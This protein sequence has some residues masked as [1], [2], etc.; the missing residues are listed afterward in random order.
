MRAVLLLPLFA[1]V[2]SPATGQVAPEI[3]PD[4]GDGGT[5]A[6]Y[7]AATL[8]EAPGRM[9]RQEDP[10]E[11][12]AVP[13]AA[14]VRRILYSSTDGRFGRGIQA[15]SG[16]LYL[17]HGAP[18][19]GGWPLLVWG[20]GTFGIA[21]VCAPS[22]KR[23]TPRD[24]AYVDRWLAKGFAVVAPDYQGLGTH[25]VHPYL[26]RK[27]EGYSVLD[28]AR[29]ALSAYP[30]KIANRVVLGGQSQGSG[31]V[32]NATYVARDYAPDLK[33]LATVATGL[34]WAA[35]RRPGVQD[36][37]TI[38]PDGARVTVLRL[39]SGGT[40]PGSPPPDT[41]LSERGKALREVARTACSRDMVPVVKAQGITADNAFTRSAAEIDALLLPLDVPKTALPVPIFV[42]TGMA[43]SMIPPKRQFAATR[44]LC[45]AGTRVTFRP[46]AGITHNG[47]SVN[48]L[49]AA[50][51]WA[52][53]LLNGDRAANDCSR[54]RD[55]G[56]LQ[57]PATA[58][59]FN[60]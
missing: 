47:S 26:D 16:L 40:K 30:G 50:V 18:P 17:P 55:P 45:H 28:A 54:L 31:A 29:A 23:P 4:F 44:A 36:V 6:F 49:D 13:A 56:A 34:V 59:P 5:S 39:M 15:A 58:I 41:L 37:I 57:P 35:P 51:P 19:K 9:I 46:M 14:S 48:A 43:D 53:A 24:A 32:L 8:P 20:H 11:G 12:F 38:T 3:D 33:V 1:L 2:V 25:G 7:R 21:D 10:G 27:S 60:D 22:W 42:G 52:Q